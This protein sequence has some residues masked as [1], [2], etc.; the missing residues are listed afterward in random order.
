MTVV[1]F[2]LDHKIKHK[3]NL[4]KELKEIGVLLV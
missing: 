2:D 3:L 1:S 4:S